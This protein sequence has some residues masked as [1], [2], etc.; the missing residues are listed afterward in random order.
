MSWRITGIRHH[1]NERYVVLMRDDNDVEAR[2]IVE[3]VADD[4][5]EWSLRFVSGAELLVG[6]SS[7]R[8]LLAVVL[9]LRRI[10]H[11]PAEDPLARAQ[12][13]YQK[14]RLAYVET[15]DDPAFQEP[16]IEVFLEHLQSH[17]EARDRFARWFIELL[18]TPNTLA[19]W[20]FAYCMHV[21]RWQEVFEAADA[22]RRR[23]DPKTLSHAA[24]VAAA[25]SDDWE[26]REFFAHIL[27]KLPPRS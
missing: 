9:D 17:P 4:R 2:A 1:S 16:D 6:H 18:E 22:I 10:D 21:L 8:Q 20:L 27:E 12:E 11:S 14:Y 13:L 3:P 24:E 25:F 23:W 7:P 26:G 5:G 19:E 15:P